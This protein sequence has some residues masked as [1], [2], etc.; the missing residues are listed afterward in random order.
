LH[1]GTRSKRKDTM[2]KIETKDST[3]IYYKDW[4]AG[5]PVVFSHGWPLTADAWDSQMLYLG[6][7]GYRVIAHDR[8]G[9]GRSGQPWNGNDMDTYADDLATLMDALDL[10]GA[11]LVGHSTGGGEVVRY[12]GRHGSKRVA[13]ITESGLGPQ[14]RLRSPESKRGGVVSRCEVRVLDPHLAQAF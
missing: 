8:R 4:G 9:H 13:K 12:M 6:Q 10:H 11:M 14:H 2:T 7:H 3:E 1:T 5:R